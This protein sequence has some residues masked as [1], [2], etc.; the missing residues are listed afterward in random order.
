MQPVHCAE[1]LM[2]LRTVTSTFARLDTQ[3][4]MLQDRARV[5]VLAR[6]IAAVGRPGDVVVEAQPQG[7]EVGWSWSVEVA[8]H[9]TSSGPARRLVERGPAR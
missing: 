2:P 5:E 3:R 4:A 1:Y 7:D 6:A 9:C 8:G